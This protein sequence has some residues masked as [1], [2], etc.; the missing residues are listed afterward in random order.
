MLLWRNYYLCSYGCKTPIWTS[1]LCSCGCKTYGH[2]NLGCWCQLWASNLYVW[3]VDD[4]KLMQYICV[5]VEKNYRIRCHV[6]ARTILLSWIL[7]EIVNKWGSFEVWLLQWQEI[8]FLSVCWIILSGESRQGQSIFSVGLL[9]IGETHIFC[10]SEL[11]FW[12]CKTD[13]R[14]YFLSMHSFSLSSSSNSGKSLD[15]ATSI[16]PVDVLP[17][18]KMAYQQE[19]K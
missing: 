2:L 12:R 7:Y 18:R 15:L 13:R 4:D 8:Y 14:H 1:Y 11:Y 19:K 3:H 17:T 10:R 9:S 6:C 5:L 16:F